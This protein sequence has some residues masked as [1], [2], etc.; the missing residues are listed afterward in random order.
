M[1]THILW[2]GGVLTQSSPRLVIGIVVDQMR[3]H[4]LT[5]F[6]SRRSEGFGKL[7]RE[8]MVY[9]NCHYNYF[10]TYT[11]A[12]HASIYT[13]TTPAIHGIVANNWWEASTQQSFY[14][15]SD[16]TARTIGSTSAAGQRSPRP[17]YTST[18]ADELR[19]HCGFRNKTIG[20]ALKD[21]SAILSVGRSATLALWFDSKAGK[22]ITSSYYAEALPAWVEQFNQKKYADSLL[23]VPWRMRYAHACTDE[24][25][26][27]NIMKGESQ[28]M[29]PHQPLDYESLLLTPAGNWITLRLAQEAIEHEKLGKGPCTDLLAISLSSPDL[30]GHFFGT[31]SCEI[32][33]LY[34]ELDKQLA[35]FLAYLQRKFREGEILLFLTADHGAMPTPEVMAEKRLPAGRYPEDS[36]VARAQ[37]FLIQSLKLSPDEKPITAFLNQSFYLS[38][39]QREEAERLLK[40]WL[41]EQPYV[42]AAYTR[43]ELISPGGTTYPFQ[44]LQAGYFPQRSGDVIVVYAPGWIEHGGYT[45]GTT[46]GSIWTYDTHV[47]LIWWGLNL[48]SE[49]HYER[50]PITAIA[51]TLALVLR[52]PFPAAAVSPPLL[53]VVEKARIPRPEPQ[54]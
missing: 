8:G 25:P 4:Y 21:R 36:L 12:G 54:N 1:L 26:Y 52:V 7:L 30:V 35:D 33:E 28:P 14:C 32:E 53:P 34:Y 23:R 29:F 20:I 18:I 38:P 42:V 19:Y 13:G 22:W 49:S 9:W 37:S 44:M 51:S 2:I 11:A 40:R 41:L 3:A 5:R 15:V 39:A 31:E 6:A 50:V 10:P 43:T 17:L 24:S 46:H 27:E 45:R 16:S 48:P 47:P